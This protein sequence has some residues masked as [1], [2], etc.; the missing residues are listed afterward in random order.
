MRE[1]Y[2]SLI[3]VIMVLLCLYV[4]IIQPTVGSENLAMRIIGTPIYSKENIPRQY[5]LQ[6]YDFYYDKNNEYYFF[7]RKI[8]INSTVLQKNGDIFLLFKN[9][10]TLLKFRIVER[11][12]N[13]YII[14]T[15]LNKSE[16]IRAC[17]NMFTE[18][19]LE[20]KIDKNLKYLLNFDKDRILILKI[21]LFRKPSAETIKI[22]YY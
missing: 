4:V 8:P 9:N 13:G 1:F 6:D 15:D 14:A 21:L 12:K 22:L 10:G 18:I 2:R 11:V 7:L 5:F 17:P 20:Y 3:F 19:P 16:L